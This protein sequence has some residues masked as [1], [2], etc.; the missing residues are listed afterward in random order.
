MVDLVDDK[1]KEK[2]ELLAAFELRLDKAEAG[3]LDAVALFEAQEAVI[4]IFDVIEGKAAMDDFVTKAL[5]KYKNPA[6][7]ACISTLRTIDRTFFRPIY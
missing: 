1:L 4:P 3:N 5:K 2:L 6:V 7:R